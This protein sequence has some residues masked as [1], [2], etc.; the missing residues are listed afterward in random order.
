MNNIEKSQNNKKSSKIKELIQNTIII[1]IG[2][3][4][5]QFISF[6]LLP[7]YTAYID[8]SEY[9]YVDLITTYVSLLITLVILQLDMAAFRFLIDYR[10]SDKG[11]KKVISNIFICVTILTLI[12]TLIY[13]VVA[14]YLLEIQHMWLVLLIIVANILS[15]VLLQIARGLGKNVDY[16]ISSIVGG[17][18]TIILN[19]V[20]IVKFR[21]GG[22][23]LLVSMLVSNLAISLYLTVRLKPFRMI[24]LRYIDKNM[25]KELVKYSAPLVPHQISMWIISVSDRTIIS[26]VLGTAA[27]GIYSIANKFSIILNSIYNVFYLAWLEQAPLHYN[28]DDRDSY[29]SLIINNG[30]K[31][32]GTGCLLIITILP[33]IFNI[34]INQNYAEAYNQI[35]ILLVGT[36]FSIMVG[37]TGVVYVSEKRTKEIAKTSV[38]TSIINVLVNVL[39]IKQL[40]LYA[41]SISTL[42][43]YFGMAIYRWF[44]IKKYINIKLEKKKIWML[45]IGFIIGLYFYYINVA[46]TNILS[47]CLSILIG[48]YINKEIIVSLGKSV[49]KK[50]IK[51]K[52]KNI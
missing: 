5:T 33:I 24:R 52:Q 39:L 9:G 29:F 25:T 38:A 47:F 20:L 36:L 2:K 14:N 16:S 43:A 30:I 45:I 31:I 32:F 49:V 46:G 17:I 10:D 1:F 51:R 8:T 21:L 23:G 7:L 13:I 40:G 41:A 35:P 11:K 12:F 26:A 3:I 34:L 15:S 19:I 44:D 48:I 42:I 18:T 27:N 37:M 22:L 4:S 50:E 6:F 28:D